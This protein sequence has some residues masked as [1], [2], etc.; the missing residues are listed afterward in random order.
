MA[1][2]K[3][4]RRRIGTD[5]KK[6][7]RLTEEE[8]ARR[9][10]REEVAN[11]EEDEQYTTEEDEQYTTEEQNAIDDAIHRSNSRYDGDWNY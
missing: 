6:K 9:K 3:L 8:I 10:E 2:K 1:K 4:E 7:N 11:E 5:R